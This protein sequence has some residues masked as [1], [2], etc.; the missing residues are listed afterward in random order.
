MPLLQSLTNFFSSPNASNS[1]HGHNSRRSVVNSTFDAFSLPTTQNVGGGFGQSMDRGMQGLDS[2]SSG[3]SRRDSYVVYPP[4]SEASRHALAYFPPLSHTFHRLRNA[5]ADSFPEL[6]ETLNPPV[7]PS[8][9]ATFEAELGSPLPPPVRD[10]YLIADGQGLE[11][12]GNISGSGGLFFGLQLLPLEEVMREWAFWRA[13][14]HDPSA[15]QNLAVLATMASIPP[16]WIKPLYA[17]RGWLPL[18]TDRTGNYVGVDLDPGPDG[19][20]GQV[21]VFGRDF[22]RKCVL[23][24]GEGEGGWGKWMAAFVD[25]LESGEGWEADKSNS[26]DEEEEVGY[27]SYNGGASYGEAGRGLRLAGEYRGWS[28]LE[29]WWDRSVRKW[30]E[31]GLGMDV[32]AIERG[33]EEAR[34]LA[35]VDEKG[36]GKQTAV[37]IRAGE[38]SAQVEIPVI[39]S[40]QAPPAPSTP[41]P[42]DS[43]VL[44]PPSSPDTAPVPK[45][46]YAAPS[47]VRVITPIAS[48]SDHP[49]K[50]PPINPQGYLS[51]PSRSPPRH[52]PQRRSTLPPTPTPLDLPTRA[53]MQAMQ[54]IATVEANNLRG[55]WVMNLETSAAARRYRNSSDSEMV[56]IDLEGGRGE[57]FGSPIITTDVE[58]VA[59]REEEK[60]SMANIDNRRSPRSSPQLIQSR[61][62]SPLSRDPSLEL[63]TEQ[64]PRATYRQDAINI[65]PSV[66]AATSALRR[67]PPIVNHS[68]SIRRESDERHRVI[69]NPNSRRERESSVL[70]T[71]SNDGL[72]DR[73]RSFSQDSHM[74]TPPIISSPITSPRMGGL[75]LSSPTIHVTPPPSAPTSPPRQSMRLVGSNV[76]PTPMGIE[77]GMV[78]VSLEPS[79]SDMTIVPDRRGMEKEEVLSPISARSS[80]SNG[81]S[82]TVGRGV[83]DKEMGAVARAKAKLGVAG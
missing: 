37:G 5:L 7:D 24:R 40:P 18:L 9:L 47:P 50:A 17:C 78:E 26:S 3:P 16:N 39:G 70:S 51:P 52:Q 15:G 21:I 83:R 35:G 69:R 34:K 30:E 45:I 82:S 27:G 6:L 41:V 76:K 64:T 77:D 58:L 20:W 29:A 22:D 49:L 81:T 4:K 48:T 75:S 42:G 67:P 79:T 56:D 1:R 2:P 38:S 19:A 32:E 25:E 28:V 72:L 12:T 55:G 63:P 36:K 11:A 73:D 44:L 74:D 65:P 54:A 13:A 71:D 14:E 23:W 53:D 66:L 8:L 33:L 10:C 68:D 60:L 80:M 59:Q 62:P 46:R 31:S 61:T 57:K 43:D